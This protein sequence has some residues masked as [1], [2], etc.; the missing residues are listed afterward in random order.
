MSSTIGAGFLQRFFG[1][2]LGMIEPASENSGCPALLE[3][4]PGA[5]VPR[6][7][8]GEARVWIIDLDAGLAPGDGAETAEPGPELAWLS[9]DEQA[10][11]A[12]FVRARDR[13]RFVQCRAALRE[14]LG[15][16]LGEPAA[17][18]R[19]QAVGMGKPELDPGHQSLPDRHDLG[20]IRLPLRFNVSHSAELGLIAV[21]RGREVGVDLERVRPISE[22]GRIVASYFTAAEQAVFAAL[23]ADAQAL[24]FHRG[25]TR[26]EAILKGTGMGLA[27][28]SARPETGFGTTGLTPRFTLAGPAARVAPWVLWE[29]APRPGFV[30]ALA[31]HAGLTLKPDRAGANAALPAPP[32]TP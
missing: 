15:R 3:W 24:A 14:I 22:A 1:T 12:R 27:G 31:V 10:R 19:F 5:D 9:A 28:L 6:L 13:R 16:L 21:C 17:S 4:S 25:W 7:A 2:F 20:T 11:S 26:K 8:P 18:L 23:A 29:A 32:A 30:A